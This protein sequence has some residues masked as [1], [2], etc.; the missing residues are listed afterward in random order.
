MA[1]FRKRTL[2]TLHIASHHHVITTE[3]IGEHEV[4]TGYAEWAR[5]RAGDKEHLAVSTTA[6][7]ISVKAQ[8]RR[9]HP[10]TIGRHL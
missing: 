7:E 6:G 2:K 1:Y 3:V 8:P 5:K 9:M 4:V 10:L